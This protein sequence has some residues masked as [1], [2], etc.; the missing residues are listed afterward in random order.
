MPVVDRLGVAGGAVKWH[1][2]VAALP[3]HT[4]GPFADGAPAKV[5][6]LLELCG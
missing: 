2:I 5:R 4:R 6:Q 3:E 1:S